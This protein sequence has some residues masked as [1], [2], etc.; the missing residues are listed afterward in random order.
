MPDCRSPEWNIAGGKTFD[1]CEVSRDGHNYVVKQEGVW[2]DG[3][4][5]R[6]DKAARL[7]ACVEK[8]WMRHSRS[9]SIPWP[10]YFPERKR[11]DDVSP[12]S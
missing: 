11:N 5:M 2:S 12:Q 8:R 6:Q 1:E 9:S 3:W 7:L 4:K 10:G